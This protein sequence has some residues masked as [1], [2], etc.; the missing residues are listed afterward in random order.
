MSPAT[1]VLTHVAELQAKALDAGVSVDKALEVLRRGLAEL[2]D[3]DRWI[4]LVQHLQS[5]L[6]TRNTYTDEALRVFR[7][8]VTAGLDSGAVLA[9]A[10]TPPAPAAKFPPYLADLLD[11]GCLLLH[12]HGLGNVVQFEVWRE[13]QTVAYTARLVFRFEQGD[14]APRQVVCLARTGDFVCQS[15]PGDLFAVD[16]SCWDIPVPPDEVDREVWEQARRNKKR[17]AG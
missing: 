10:H 11:R 12:V 4:A 6:S 16:A 1:E 14:N 13:G 7:A 9:S 5:A 2:A 17:R 3:G 8:A 15:V